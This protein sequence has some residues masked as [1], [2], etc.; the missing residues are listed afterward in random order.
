MNLDN[1]ALVWHQSYLKCRDSIV[2]PNWDEYIVAPAKTFSE[3]F[4]DLM[5]ELK[6]LM[7]TGSV[8]EF[9]FAFA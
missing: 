4:S 9:Q 2:P 3:E 7:Q 5:L 1:E 8:R 6:Q